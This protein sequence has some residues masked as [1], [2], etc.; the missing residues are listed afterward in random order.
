MEKIL[1][2]KENWSLVDIGYVELEIRVTLIEA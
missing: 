1:R 2:S